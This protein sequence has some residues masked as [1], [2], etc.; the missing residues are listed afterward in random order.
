MILIIRTVLAGILGL[1]IGSFLLVIVDRLN[2]GMS[3]TRGR[4]IC[5]S[6]GRTLGVMDLIPIF[7]FLWLRGRCRTCNATFSWTYPAVEALTA[8]SFVLIS[9]QGYSLWLTIVYMAITGMLIPL[10]VYDLRHLILPDVLTYTLTGLGVVLVA[11]GAVFPSVGMVVFGQAWYFHLLA[12]VIIPLPFWLLWVFSKGRLIGFGDIKLMVPI[13]ILLGLWQGVSAVVIAFWLG[14]L[15]VVLMFVKAL[16]QNLWRR[17]RKKT[18][19]S[20]FTKKAFSQ[21]IP[22]GPFLVLGLWIVL[23]FQISMLDIVQWFL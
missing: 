7:S 17:I 1:I 21:Q 19:V 4:S 6:C 11:V 23:V 2:T 12:G 10:A 13:G 15:F 8:L 16:V 22:F 5:M 3:I 9:L 18:N 20:V 14:A